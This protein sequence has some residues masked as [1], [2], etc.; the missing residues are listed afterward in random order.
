MNNNNEAMFQGDNDKLQHLAILN[1]TISNEKL[2]HFERLSKID[3]SSKVEKKGKFDYLPWSYAVEEMT[4][5]C[6]EWTYEIEHFNNLP[7]VYDEKTGYM[8]FTNITAFEIKKRMWLPVMD[9]QNKAKKNADMMDINKTIMRCLVKN[10]AMFGLGL[11]I[12]EGEELPEDCDDHLKNEQKTISPIANIE[13]SKTINLQQEKELSI[14]LQSCKSGTLEKL[15][16]AYQIQTLNEI[17]ESVFE[18]IKAKI[19]D[20]IEKEQSIG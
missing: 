7:Y 3:V 10:I 20:K 9:F 13:Q 2:Q 12:F 4:K 11:Y 17:K 8:I 16:N 5:V 1:N 18:K 6:P 14:L 15:L 19:L